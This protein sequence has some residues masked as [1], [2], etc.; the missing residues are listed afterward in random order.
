VESGSR[1]EA[2]YM[3]V[4]GTCSVHMALKDGQNID[5]QR[6]VGSW[7]PYPMALDTAAPYDLVATP[8]STFLVIRGTLN[9]KRLV[10]PVIKHSTVDY[11]GALTSVFKELSHH[12][13]VRLLAISNIEDA[14]KDHM[15]IR[16]GHMSSSLALMVRGNCMMT[17]SGSRLSV[18]ASPHLFGQVSIYHDLPNPVSVRTTAPA[19]FILIP[20][21][22]LLSLVQVHC[23]F[24]AEFCLPR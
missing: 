5:I 12:E 1:C 16:E 3:V 23:C 6:S 20:K 2:L 14:R 13:I 22:E 11:V 24:C 7:F 10:Q 8:G 4:E 15:V 18:V 21:R 9:F 17:K 19:K